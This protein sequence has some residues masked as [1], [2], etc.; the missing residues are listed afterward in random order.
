MQHFVGVHIANG[1]A[2]LV[3]PVDDMLFLPVLGTLISLLGLF[4]F[5]LDMLIDVS[6]IGI[7][8]DNVQLVLFCL[9]DLLKLDD[10]RTIQLFHEFGL[11]ESHGQCFFVFILVHMR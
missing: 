5:L 11:L 1:V 2:N 10:V 8:H 6:T 9:V 7:L 4:N 3:E